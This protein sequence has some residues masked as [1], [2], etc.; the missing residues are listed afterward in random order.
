MTPNAFDTATCKEV[1]GDARTRTIEGKARVDADRGSFD[2]PAEVTSGSYWS[3]VTDNMER[4]IYVI[5]HG[6]RLERI[7]RM[8]SKGDK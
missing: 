1:A 5:A 4:I 6:K 2:P 7:G 3:Q 8:N